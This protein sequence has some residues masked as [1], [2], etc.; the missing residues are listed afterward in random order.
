VKHLE[1]PS[2]FAIIGAG[3]WSQ[4][5]GHAWRELPGATCV[6][7]CDQNKPKAEELAHQL[8]VQRV[9]TDADQLLINESLSFVDIITTEESHALLVE[10]ALTRG[11]VAICQKP[12]APSLPVCRKLV[13]LSREHNTTIFVHENFRFQAPMRA[14]EAVIRQGA[15]GHPYRARISMVTG[16]PV[17]ANQPNLKGLKRFILADLGCHILDLARYFMGEV[18]SLMATQYRVQN[19]IA[20]EDIATVLLKCVSGATVICE[21]GLAGTPR[22]DD[23]FPQTLVRIEGTMGTVELKKDFQ[24]VIT[25]AQGSVSQLHAPNV[26]SWADPN[27]L[28]VHES[29]VA[30][31]RDILNDIHGES[32]SQ[33]RASDNVKT[34]E[35]V[36]GAYESIATGRS[37]SRPF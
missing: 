30:C 36:F 20:G 35:L 13:E 27:Y 3:F 16:F 7:I 37:L 1:A 22:A 14:L 19:D 6:A 32:R 26:Y 29:I 21:M 5:Q 17:F 24:V 25:T 10:K 31:N 18:E 11:V 4:F 9:Y 12:L 23:A 2:P 8:G 34:M 15:I 33:T 28:V